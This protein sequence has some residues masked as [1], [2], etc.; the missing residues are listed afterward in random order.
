MHFIGHCCCAEVAVSRGLTVIHKILN[1]VSG[2]L[3]FCCIVVCVRHGSC[4]LD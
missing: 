4:M 3:Q 1:I 2:I